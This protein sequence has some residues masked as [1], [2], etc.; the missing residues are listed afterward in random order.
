MPLKRT[1]YTLANMTMPAQASDVNADRSVVWGIKAALKGVTVPGD[2]GASG[3]A[4]VGSS[5]TVDGSSDSVTGAMD[6]VDRW[7]DTFDPAKVVNSNNAANAPRS[8]VSLRAPAA[9]GFPFWLLLHYWYNS[10]GAQ[11]YMVDVWISPEA[12]T[13]GTATSRPSVPA[14]ALQLASMGM[15]LLDNATGRYNTTH[16]LHIVR[17]AE[18]FFLLVFTRGGQGN[19]ALRHYLALW[20]KTGTAPD[21]GAPWVFAANYGAAAMAPTS[22]NF[23][24]TELFGRTRGNATWQAQSLVYPAYAASSSLYSLPDT[25]VGVNPDTGKWDEW[26]AHVV[27]AVT[28]TY[29]LRGAME[30]WGFVPTAAPFLGTA[31]STGPVERVNMGGML[32]PFGV[33][34]IP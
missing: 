16:R 26:P 11:S 9:L 29:R 12:F 10:T 30:D 32:V 15:Q 27:E 4:P 7:G 33:A 21:D 23:G 24:N 2:L 6:G 18:G 1:W 20:P 17:S 34:P 14:S 28:G 13:G 25:Q 3:A 19:A 22:V 31:P 8:W 5:W